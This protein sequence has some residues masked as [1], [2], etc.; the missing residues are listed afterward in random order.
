MYRKILFQLNPDVWNW[1]SSNVPATAEALRPPIIATVPAWKEWDLRSVFVTIIADER[2]ESEKF[3]YDFDYKIHIVKAWD[4]WA[5]KNC[6]V[7]YPIIDLKQ[8]RLKQHNFKDLFLNE[9][10]SVYVYV[11]WWRLAFQWFW[12]EYDKQEYQDYL[13]TLKAIRDIEW[14]IEEIKDEYLLS[15]PTLTNNAIRDQS[16]SVIDWNTNNYVRY[17]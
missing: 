16:Q 8:D 17:P 1:Q 2:L 15:L 5:E 10:D 11:K 12:I 13:D 6:L 7:H 9:W 14:H 3:S 4:W